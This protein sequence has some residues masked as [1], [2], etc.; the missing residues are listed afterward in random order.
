MGVIESE[1]GVPK[2]HLYFRKC[3]PATVQRLGCRRDKRGSGD[4]S[5]SSSSTGLGEVDLQ[6]RVLVQAAMIEYPRPGSL[7]NR[8][9]FSHNFRG[10]KPKGWFLVRPLSLACKQLPSHCVLV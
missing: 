8:N 6:T 7:D 9:L 3:S 1:L 2:S 4:T 10:Y 5:Y